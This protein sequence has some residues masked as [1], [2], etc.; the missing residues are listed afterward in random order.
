MWSAFKVRLIKAFQQM[1]ER[2]QSATVAVEP[3]DAGELRALQMPLLACRADALALGADR[4]LG[5]A[6]GPEA[7]PAQGLRTPWVAF[8]VLGDGVEDFAQG[9]GGG[10]G[11]G[12]E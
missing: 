2:L 8:G 5:R 7:H 1:R 11:L 12:G 4:L 9:P 3:S 6:G 10:L